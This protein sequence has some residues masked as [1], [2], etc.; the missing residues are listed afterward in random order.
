MFSC[1]LHYMHELVGGAK[2]AV[3]LIFFWGGSVEP[4]YY[5]IELYISTSCRFDRLASFKLFLD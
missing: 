5:I 2:Q 3:M 4:Y 1:Y